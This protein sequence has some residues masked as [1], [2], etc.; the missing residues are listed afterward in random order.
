[1]SRRAR[2]FKK[3]LDRIGQTLQ[4][5][6]SAAKR[7]EGPLGQ[8]QDFQVALRA[9]A[10]ALQALA[11]KLTEAQASQALNSVLKQIDNA[12]RFLCSRG[13]GPTARGA[14]PGAPGAGGQ[15]DRGG[16]N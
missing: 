8:G 15:A 16:G 11:A 2:R 9:L 5:Q 13:A 7:T 14:G 4:A 12:T 3:I 10:E 6:A 1:M